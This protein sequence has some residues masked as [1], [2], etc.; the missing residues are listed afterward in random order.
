MR[1]NVAFYLVMDPQRKYAWCG[2]G[3]GFHE[4]GASIAVGQFAMLAD[5]ESAIIKASEVGRQ[6]KLPLVSVAV[7][8]G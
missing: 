4:V 6:I 1:R 2:P 5:K 7:R 3:K 8:I